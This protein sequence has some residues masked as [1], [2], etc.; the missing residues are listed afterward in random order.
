MCIR[1]RSEV[2]FS[3]ILCVSLATVLNRACSPWNRA[4]L[5]A[6]LC[7][8]S[9]LGGW[10]CGLTRLSNKVSLLQDHL[11]LVLVGLSLIGGIGFLYPQ[12]YLLMELL[13]FRH[14]L[15]CLRT[16]LALQR[17]W[18]ESQRTQ[19]LNAIHNLE[20]RKAGGPTW[21][22][23]VGKLNMGKDKVPSF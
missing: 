2:R 12:P 20:R 16:W 15:V 9:S 18:S 3:S 7:V 10:P 6:L 4:F 8:C 23:V 13:N 14:S 11:P 21:S 19:R 5:L 17:P 1:D 22:H